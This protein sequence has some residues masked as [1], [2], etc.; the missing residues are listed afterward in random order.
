MVSKANSANKTCIYIDP[1]LKE[2]HIRTGQYRQSKQ[3][4]II[5]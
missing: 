4:T 3:H 5:P 2:T 1:A